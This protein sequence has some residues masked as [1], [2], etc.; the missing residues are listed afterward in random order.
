MPIATYTLNGV[1]VEDYGLVVIR[2]DG[3]LSLPRREYSLVQLPLRDGSKALSEASMSD[4]RVIALGLRIEPT[5]LADRRTKLNTLLR[6]LRG[7]IEVAT[8]ED[9]TKVCYGLIQE[10]PVSHFGGR[11]FAILPVQC[12]LSVLCPDPLWYDATPVSVSINAVDT[13]VALPMG[14]GSARTRKLRIRLNGSFTS[15]ITVILKANGAELA[16]MT[17]ASSTTSSEYIEIDCDA[18]TITKYSSGV[19]TDVL[20]TLTV[21]HDFFALDPSDGLTLEI[22]KGTAVAYLTRAYLS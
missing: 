16:R 21:T 5:T 11:P 19:G 7:Q 14:V 1:P 4:P 2:T 3:A 13:P 17:I 9:A 20:S 22:N 18:F 12:D 15:P 8:V 10:G 6:D